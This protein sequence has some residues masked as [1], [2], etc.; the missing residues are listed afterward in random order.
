MASRYSQDIIPNHLS[1]FP[2]LRPPD[3]K[4]LIKSSLCS[5]TIQHHGWIPPLFHTWWTSAIQFHFPSGRSKPI[6]LKEHTFFPLGP[7]RSKCSMWAILPKVDL[8]FGHLLMKFK[9]Q[10]E[11]L[12]V[13][14][15]DLSSRGHL[16]EM[17]DQF[18][19]SSC[20]GAAQFLPFCSHFSGVSQILYTTP[21]SYCLFLTNLLY[22][23]LLEMDSG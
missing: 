14:G 22:F 3:T 23:I 11:R 12:K 10:A 21:C 2:S 16:A 4:I 7:H 6:L 19:P 13:V 1:N 9:S 8:L 18:R 5:S 15:V 20:P 17:V